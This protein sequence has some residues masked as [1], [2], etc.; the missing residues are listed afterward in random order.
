[1]ITTA[2]ETLSVFDAAA[3][4]EIRSLVWKRCR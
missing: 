2:P 3:L 4:E 1:M